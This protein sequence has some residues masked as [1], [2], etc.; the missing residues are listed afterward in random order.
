MRQP[1]ATQAEQPFIMISRRLVVAPMGF[2]F[3]GAGGEASR[4]LALPTRY[5]AAT[6]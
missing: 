4:D 2:L 5:V 6:F 1:L 3:D